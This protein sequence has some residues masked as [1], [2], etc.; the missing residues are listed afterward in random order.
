MVLHAN[1]TADGGRVRWTGSV[2]A[3]PAPSDLLSRSTLADDNRLGSLAGLAKL[4]RAATV[5]A[6]E[7]S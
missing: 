7:G 5:D 4:M 2:G 1:L 6:G 3:R